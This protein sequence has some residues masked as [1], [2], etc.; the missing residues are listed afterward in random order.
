MAEPAHQVARAGE[1]LLDGHL[2]IEQHADEQRERAG[3]QQFV[4]VGVDRQ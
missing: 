4:G 3:R 1:S 2:L